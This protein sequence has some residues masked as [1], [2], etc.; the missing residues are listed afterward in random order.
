MFDHRTLSPTDKLRLARTRSPNSTT[1][2][3]GNH[4]RPPTT[5]PRLRARSASPG[6]EEALTSE[7]QCVVI[8]HYGVH[9]MISP[10]R[11]SVKA[12]K[13]SQIADSSAEVLGSHSSGDG[14][15]GSDHIQDLYDAR[16]SSE[17]N[18]LLKKQVQS[19]NDK[20]R[21]RLE[22]EEIEKARAFV[23]EEY[24]KEGTEWEVHRSHMAL[25]K[26][27]Q[28][29]LEEEER[30]KELKL[31]EPPEAPVTTEVDR[32]ES[33]ESSKSGKVDQYQEVETEK[34]ERVG[35]SSKRRE[36]LLP[37]KVSSPDK[38]LSASKRRLSAQLDNITKQIYTSPMATDKTK[39]A[40]DVRNTDAIEAKR[41]AV[42]VAASSEKSEISDSVEKVMTQGAK[43]FN[44]ID[45][46]EAI[47][48]EEEEE[49]MLHGLDHLEVHARE[50]RNEK[51]RRPRWSFGDSWIEASGNK[52]QV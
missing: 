25:A 32:M 24:A 38:P 12:K 51:R 20:L 14:M 1:I 52:R 15:Q 29:A 28:M 19:Y 49:H 22:Q 27:E 26:Q 37:P 31:L 4:L 47:I 5:T 33:D 39:I 34:V 43:I 36:S 7:Q 48:E 3:P 13:G 10:V 35:S 21:L 42:I 11:E 23:E 9:R 41:E 40:P 16:Q 18:S 30:T 46:E 6:F 50:A 44:D 8:D 17:K 45:D 2:S